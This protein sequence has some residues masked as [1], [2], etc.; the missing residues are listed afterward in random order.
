MRSVTLVPS[1][2]DCIGV[3]PG[4]IAVQVVRRNF[5][6]AARELVEHGTPAMVT[7][8]LDIL[9]KAATQAERAGT[10]IRRLDEFVARGATERSPE[11]LN[12]VIEEAAALALVGAREQ[13]VRVGLWLQSE[14][15]AVMIDKVQIH[16]VVGEPR[17]Q[18]AGGD[19]RRQATGALD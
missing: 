6:E 7:R 11:D 19:A 8:I 2:D 12:K 17:T 3:P 13:G 16:Q 15:P 4:R 1:G 10:I 14:L 18:C 9:T 5:V